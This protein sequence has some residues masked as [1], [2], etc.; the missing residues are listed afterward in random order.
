MQVISV[1]NH[2]SHE[3]WENIQEA[4]SAAR[5]Y[6]TCDLWYTPTAHPKYRRKIRIYDGGK[7]KIMG[8]YNWSTPDEIE[9]LTRA[10][11]AQWKT[12]VGQKFCRTI[13]IMGDRIPQEKRAG[14]LA[15]RKHVLPNSAYGMPL[16]VWNWLRS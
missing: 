13:A 15:M 16:I 5:K 14:L 10:Y 1:G 4:W 6:P 7:W 8:E 9:M 11:K 12:K 3:Y 2:F